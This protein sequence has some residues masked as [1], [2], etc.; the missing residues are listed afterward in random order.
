MRSCR[1]FLDASWHSVLYET[2][3]LYS[4]GRPRVIVSTDLCSRLLEKSVSETGGVVIT[5]STRGKAQQRF[6]FVLSA[7][8]IYIYIHRVY[9]YINTHI[10]IYIYKYVYYS[11]YYFTCY[12]IHYYVYIFI[13]IQYIF[14]QTDN[15]WL[16]TAT[17][18]RIR[19]CP[20]TQTQLGSMLHR[21]EGRLMG[22]ITGKPW[23]KW[24]F[25]LW[26]T[27]ITMENHDVCWE[28]SLYMALFN[29]Y[30]LV[31]QRVPATIGYVDILRSFHLFWTGLPTFFGMHI[32]FPACT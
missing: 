10:Y 1:A 28:N 26:E 5:S 7:E 17:V 12:D 25:I 4:R 8:Y 31:C 22:A 18:A 9:I 13:Y 2:T 29:S 6:T 19:T 21:T 3:P 16:Q 30:M 14:W 32:H 23:E 20:M 11:K 24:R 27:N 15:K